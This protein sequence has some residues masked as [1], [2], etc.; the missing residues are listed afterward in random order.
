[1]GG[2]AAEFANPTMNSA[3]LRP[4]SATDAGSIIDCDIAAANGSHKIWGSWQCGPRRP[5]PTSSQT[6]CFPPG[7]RTLI[8]ASGAEALLHDF[9]VAAPM[10][11]EATYSL[12]QIGEYIRQ[13]TG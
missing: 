11:P 12:R 6:R 7:P 13:A 2:R 4:N 3:A 9:Q 10:L 8:H 5:I 1:M